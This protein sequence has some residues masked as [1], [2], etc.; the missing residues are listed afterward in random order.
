MNTGKAA[1][2]STSSSFHIGISPTHWYFHK[3]RNWWTIANFTPWI[4]VVAF[5]L[6]F[7]FALTVSR[8]HPSV[9]VYCAALFRTQYRQNA[10]S[11]SLDYYLTFCIDYATT[12]CHDGVDGVGTMIRYGW[13]VWRFR[14]RLMMRRK[15][16]DRIMCMDYDSGRERVC[17]HIYF[18]SPGRISIQVQFVPLTWLTHPKKGAHTIGIRNIQPARLLPFS[19]FFLFTSL[20]PFRRLCRR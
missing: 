9:F 15:G 5:G 6:P 2:V 17:A 20:L 13:R 8:C 16:V 19:F 4:C 3:L 12:V 11:G 10:I 18:Q 7:S 1:T 14:G